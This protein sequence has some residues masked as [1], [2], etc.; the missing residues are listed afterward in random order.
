MG[1][2]VKKISSILL[3]ALLVTMLAPASYAE[4]VAEPYLAYQTTEYGA[5]VNKLATATEKEAYRV[6]KLLMS[7][8]EQV[9]LCFI[10][11]GSW[12]NSKWTSSDTNV[13]TIDGKGMITAKNPGVSE[14]TLTYKKK[15]M[16]CM[17]TR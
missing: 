7:P 5:A 11:A 9:D 16:V 3:F 13:A 15:C 8:G 1:K 10:N 2:Y 17:I 14:I 12:K 4:A 6:E